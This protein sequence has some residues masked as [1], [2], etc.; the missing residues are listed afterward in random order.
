MF[1]T[2]HL[3]SGVYIS[4]FQGMW[5]GNPPW[6]KGKAAIHGAHWWRYPGEGSVPVWQRP[7]RWI[8]RWDSICW[9]SIC[10]LHYWGQVSVVSQNQDYPAGSRERGLFSGVRWSD[11]FPDTK[12]THN[13]WHQ[14]QDNLHL[15]TANSCHLLVWTALDLVILP[16]LKDPTWADNTDTLETFYK[17]CFLLNI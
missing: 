7:A 3:I 5:L 10:W 6:A 4:F 11:C 15:T 16:V 8:S 9:D 12:H 2:I 14:I 13:Y 1:P 17:D